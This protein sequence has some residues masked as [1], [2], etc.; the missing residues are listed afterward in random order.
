MI[1]V[2]YLVLVF[3]GVGSTS[4]AAVAIP[5]ANA[6]QCEINSKNYKKD[7]NTVKK[8]YCIVGVMPK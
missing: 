4:G 2:V 5:Q 6:Q 7:V 8:S 1:N 3:Y